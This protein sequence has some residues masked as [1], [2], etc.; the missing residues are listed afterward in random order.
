M[1]VFHEFVAFCVVA[2]NAEYEAAMTPLPVP[3]IATPAA[4]RPE[5]RPIW[6]VISTG[7]PPSASVPP[8]APRGSR[9]RTM[10]G[11][12][13]RRIRGNRDLHELT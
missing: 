11:P 4:M 10:A 9:P 7:V 8:A 13:R 5:S 6:R 2:L 12:S 1:P 3:T